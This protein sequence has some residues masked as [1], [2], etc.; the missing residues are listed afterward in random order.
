MVKAFF[1]YGRTKTAYKI[2]DRIPLEK[3]P[4]VSPRHRWKEN[5]KAE[6]REVDW[7]YLKWLRVASSSW[8]C[9]FSNSLL[10][11]W[12][13]KCPFNISVS[14]VLHTLPCY[15]L[16]MSHHTVYFD[17]LKL[18]NLKYPLDFNKELIL[19]KHGDVI[20]ES[21]ETKG[22]LKITHWALI[23]DILLS[24]ITT[25]N[26]LYQPCY[27]L[28]YFLEYFSAKSVKISFVKI[29]RHWLKASRQTGM[30]LAFI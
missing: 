26:F 3:I 5:I 4:L 21:Y 30:K 16:H 28:L 27:L 7:K 18:L 10:L 11:H 25:G 12:I 19:L 24:S 9:I 23:Q 20:S 17:F 8:N 13:S 29:S 2:L 1:M 6:L 22:S 15:L 14:L